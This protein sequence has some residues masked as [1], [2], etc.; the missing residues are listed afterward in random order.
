MNQIDIIV[1]AVKSV[2]WLR[3][4]RVGRSNLIFKASGGTIWVDRGNGWR[5]IIKVN[6]ID[7][8]AIKVLARLEKEGVKY[9]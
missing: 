5:K 4:F 9:E 1:N 6:D 7:T 3:P 2:E 8:N